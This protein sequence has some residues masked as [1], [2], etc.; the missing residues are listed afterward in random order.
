MVR[1]LFIALSISIFASSC[2]NTEESSQI[3][4]NLQTQIEELNIQLEESTSNSQSEVLSEMEA[5]L[6]ALETL[7]KEATSNDQ[8]EILA[9]MEYEISELTFLLEKNNEM[10]VKE[11]EE[12]ESDDPE[13]SEVAELR[14]QIALLLNELEEVKLISNTTTTSVTTTVAVNDETETQPYVDCGDGTFRPMTE[15]W[16][17]C[18]NIE[19]CAIRCSWFES[20]TLAQSWLDSN[21]DYVPYVEINPDIMSL[22]SNW[23]LATGVDSNG[24]GTACSYGD[25]GAEKFLDDQFGDHSC[26]NQG[27]KTAGFCDGIQLTCGSFSTQTDAQEWFEANLDFVQNVDDNNDGVACGFGDYGGLTDCGVPDTI[28]VLA[29]QCGD[30]RDTS[31]GYTAGAPNGVYYG[32]NRFFSQEDAQE[33]F[34]ANLAFGEKVD[35]NQDGTACGDGDYGS[36]KFGFCDAQQKGLCSSSFEMASPAIVIPPAYIPEPIY[37]PEP[38]YMPAPD[39]AA[40]PDPAVA[41]DETPVS[42]TDT[43]ST[44]ETASATN[45]EST[46]TVATTTVIPTPPTIDTQAPIVLNVNP[47]ATSVNRGGLLTVTWDLSDVSGMQISEATGYGTSEGNFSSWGLSGAGA[48][49]M[50][51]VASLYAEDDLSM[52]NDMFR[53]A[54]AIVVGE[55]FYP[56]TGYSDPNAGLTMNGT[57]RQTVEV[58]NFATPGTYDLRIWSRDNWGNTNWT[59]V[60]TIE[61]LSE[62]VEPDYPT[63]IDSLY[64]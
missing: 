27:T 58:D 9:E 35:T 19:G 23:G 6:K 12:D 43:V 15:C 22:Y 33:W 2:S 46:E 31:L 24:D 48:T 63:Y 7:L 39:P 20:Q 32:C 45:P 29:W 17:S 10:P 30:N 14:N 16:W 38:V 55:E 1:F 26:P 13:S 59:T 40:P 42:T 51:L 54:E 50:D 56:R 49:K 8:S 18:Q 64:E 36:G 44:P 25:W 61:V 53:D 5:E 47:E 21:P 52:S 28:L 3:V 62:I 37:I 60:G 4:N 34:E 41:P 57:F 11:E